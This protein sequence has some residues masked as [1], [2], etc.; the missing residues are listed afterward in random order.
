M[1]KTAVKQTKKQKQ[2]AERRFMRRAVFFSTILMAITAVFAMRYY[3]NRQAIYTEKARAAMERGE[4]EA[5]E[6]LLEKAASAQ[7]ETQSAEETERLLQESRMAAAQSLLDAGDYAAAQDAF[8]ALGESEK[9][10]ECRYLSAMA[11]KDSGAYAAAAEAFFALSGYTDALTQ[12]DSCRFLYAGTLEAE[13]KLSEAF[14]LY[15]QL[16]TYTG[17]EDK[18]KETALKITGLTDPDMAV[19]L[20]SGY[21]KEEIAEIERLYTVRTALPGQVLAV[22]FYH[23]VGLCP[24]GTAVCCGRNTE[25]QCEVSAWS[26]LVAVDAGAYHTVGLK[27]D[28]TLVACGRNTEG[29]CEVSAWTD[30]TAI[31]CSDYGTAGLKQDG[32]VVYTGFSGGTG[33]SGWQDVKSLG[34]GAY[35]TVGIRAGGTLLSTHPSAVNTDWD[36]LCTADANTGYA[37]GLRQDGRVVSTAEEIDWTDCVAVSAGSTGYGALTSEGRVL[38]RFFE[39]RD[40]IDFSDITEAVAL[41]VGGTHT[42]VLLKDGTVVCRGTNEYGECD[43]AAFRLKT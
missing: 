5:A 6:A 42:A 13:G 38:C 19:Q 14:A 29:Q 30:I 12:Y 10:L 17:A 39:Q 36:S 24:D 41:A 18:A 37:L 8:S 20:A 23:T 11:L 15:K 9:V 31:A 26:N 1:K 3:K 25:G 16:G 22:G 40:A 35:I 33:V 27:A 43:T 32:T 28:G 4:Y 7:T 21:S 34:G 2:R